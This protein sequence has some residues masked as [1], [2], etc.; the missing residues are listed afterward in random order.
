ML[1]RDELLELLNQGLSVKKISDQIDGVT[2]N[3]VRS[4]VEEY[5][6]E[7]SLADRS[8]YKWT[9]HEN[10]QL[11]QKWMSEPRPLM[12]DLAAHHKRSIGAVSTRIRL[13]IKLGQLPP[14]AKPHTKYVKWKAEEI[15]QL[16]N[17]VEQGKDF[18]DIASI[19]GRSEAS[20]R[21]KFKNVSKKTTNKSTDDVIEITISGS[22]LSTTIKIPRGKVN[23]SI[24]SYGWETT[25]SK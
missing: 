17:L 3:E 10:E 13:L 7:S 22:G 23:I 14:S 21:T 25:V 4:L 5:S 12:E 18:E 8:H 6:L 16:L 15:D 2:L 9:D 1:S 20:V 24:P 19:L 11:I